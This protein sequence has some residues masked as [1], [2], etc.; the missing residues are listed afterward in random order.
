M[1]QWVSGSVGQWVSFEAFMSEFINAGAT[2]LSL[3]GLTAFEVFISE[4]IHASAAIV[5][6]AGVTAVV[7]NRFRKSL[8]GALVVMAAI[9]PWLMINGFYMNWSWLQGEWVGILG[10]FG[11]SPLFLIAFFLYG[12]GI[13]APRRGFSAGASLI[14]MFVALG[15]TL[16]WFQLFSKME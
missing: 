2:I 5:S 14:G 12:V 9:C 15:N 10:L 13:A 8:A 4:C 6:I 1:G 16:L 3:S 7:V 11:A